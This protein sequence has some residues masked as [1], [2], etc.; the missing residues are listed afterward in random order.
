M[1]PKQFICFFTATL[2]TAGATAGTRIFEAEEDGVPSFSDTP[3]SGATEHDVPPV[4]TYESH[5]NPEQVF[6]FVPSTPDTYSALDIL[7]P[8]QDEDYR[9]DEGQV[10]INLAVTPGLRANDQ[11]EVFMNGEKLG[12]VRDTKVTLGNVYRGTHTLQVQIVNESGDPVAKSGEVTFFMQRTTPL[13]PPPV[14]VPLVPIQPAQPALPPLPPNFPTPPD[15]ATAVQDPGEPAQGG[16]G[17]DTAP[18]PSETTAIVVPQDQPPSSG[19]GGVDTAPVPPKTLAVAVPVPQPATERAGDVDT[20]PQP[21]ELALIIPQPPQPDGSETPPITIIFPVE[22][23]VPPV[24][25]AG[26]VDTTPLEPVVPKPPV[27]PPK[28]PPDGAGN[29]N[30]RQSPRPTTGAGS[31]DTRQSRIPSQGA[32]NVNTSPPVA[33]P[34]ANN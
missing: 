28:N 26:S 27:Q 11:I 7:T 2:L 30:T 9:D 10:Q 5:V 20:E 32:G 3:S 21:K 24:S 25:G 15:D 19:A 14:A 31:V 8:G 12:S 18:L 22:P 23:A 16:G 13:L 17:T 29:V 34:L 6:E 33:V 4:Q 1:F